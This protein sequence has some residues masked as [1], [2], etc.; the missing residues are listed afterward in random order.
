MIHAEHFG[1]ICHGVQVIAEKNVQSWTI[2]R[3]P[4]SGDTDFYNGDFSTILGSKSHYS[5]TS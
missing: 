1:P 2:W 4:G 5:G 3:A